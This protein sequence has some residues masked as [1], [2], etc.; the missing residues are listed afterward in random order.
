M[1]V[2]PGG[3]DIRVSI[4]VGNAVVGG[5]S[6]GKSIIC[7]GVGLGIG[8]GVG[9]GVGSGVGENIPGRVTWGVG[10]SVLL[11]P[12]LTKRDFGIVDGCCCCWIS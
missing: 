6:I 4:G 7:M 8:L 3:V 10:A 2:A 12:A 5:S 9:L 11:V 1:G